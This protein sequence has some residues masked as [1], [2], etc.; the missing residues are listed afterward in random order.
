[1]FS[2]EF[3]EI[4]KYPFFYRTSPVA[5]S[6]LK[7]PSEEDITSMFSLFGILFYFIQSEKFFLDTTKGAVLLLLN[8]KDP[9]V[10]NDQ[11]YSPGG[12]L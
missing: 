10:T 3:C 1:M 12:V 11:K 5:A 8:S 9:I 7:N 4:C 6:E 2:C